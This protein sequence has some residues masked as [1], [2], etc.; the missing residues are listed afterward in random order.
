M[1]NRPYSL[2][3]QMMRLVGLTL[4]IAIII[5]GVVLLGFGRLETQKN[6]HQDLQLISD[7]LADETSFS[8]SLGR[9]YADEVRDTLNPA[10]HH[11]DIARVCLY[12]DD[13]SLYASYLAPDIVDN[14]LSSRPSKQSTSKFDVTH[15]VSTVI[16]QPS[17][18]HAMKPTSTTRMT[19]ATAITSVS[20]TSSML[21]RMVPVRS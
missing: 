13:G 2:R 12:Q 16:S 7:I 6:I 11:A 19:R 18:G 8:L 10:K 5:S 3:L 14:C 9:D 4:S 21:A 15:S 1:S 17:G 20:C